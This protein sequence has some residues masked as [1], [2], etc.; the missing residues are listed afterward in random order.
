MNV[1]KAVH[2]WNE[3]YFKYLIEVQKGVPFSENMN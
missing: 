2:N 1:N 3:N